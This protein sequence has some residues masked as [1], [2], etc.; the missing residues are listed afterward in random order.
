[1][2]TKLIY[3]FPSNF[4]KKNLMF[5]T[6][7]PVDFLDSDNRP[8]LENRSLIYKVES[9]SLKKCLYKD[10]RAN[11][12]KLI[13]YDSLKSFIQHKDKVYTVI[14]Q[15][16]SNLGYILKDQ[17]ITTIQ[18]IYFTNYVLYKLASLSMLKNFN[19]EEIKIPV[20]YSIISRIS[21]GVINF[22]HEL[23]Y[24]QCLE[25][26]SI[27]INFEELYDIA[28]KRG[29]LIDINGACAAPAEIIKQYF[30][31]MSNS[32]NTPELNHKSLLCI[33]YGYLSFQLE[34]LSLIYETIRVKL[35]HLIN[36][37]N[38][39]VNKKHPFPLF[40]FNYCMVAHK[41]SKFSNSF[42][43]PSFMR[44]YSLYFHLPDLG[45]VDLNQILKEAKK[46]SD[47]LDIQELP[48][49]IESI[50]NFKKNANIYF[51]DIAN[52][53]KFFNFKNEIMANQI[54]IFFG[55]WP[56]L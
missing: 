29:N 39:I 6:F 36:K 34:L 8:V 24:E 46:I 40:S 32:L 27:Q 23:S 2:K 41:I 52:E 21:H 20:E 14:K 47:E 9:E 51:L 3:P 50:S 53:M 37:N 49:N 1:M 26:T 30:K 25:Q 16:C 19:E 7:C 15:L 35:W 17:K 54:D 10:S 28:N 42:E 18:T 55:E 44:T 11:T 43:H 22:V 56:P 33:K 48:I 45:T 13:N 31:V 4:M 38:D 5:L 12:E